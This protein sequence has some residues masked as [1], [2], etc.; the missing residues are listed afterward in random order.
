MGSLDSTPCASVAISAAPILE[1]TDSTSGNF[2]KACC[3]WR[4]ISTDCGRD[5]EGNRMVT[6][7]IYPSFSR[8]INSVPRNG[9]A[10]RDK[11]NIPPAP[12]RTVRRFSRA[13]AR[14]G[15]YTRWAGLHQHD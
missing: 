10:I 12:S 2:N 9:T 3:I 13:K 14:T 1:T 11:I 4:S 6:L 15:R 8:G 5:T 7:V